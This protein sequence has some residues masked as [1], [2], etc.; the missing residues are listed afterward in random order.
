MQ[1]IA[2]AV[3]GGLGAGALGVL[4]LWLFRKVGRIGVG[5]TLGI[6]V[7][8]LLSPAISLS[9][10]FAGQYYRWALRDQQVQRVLDAGVILSQ[11]T[12]EEPTPATVYVVQRGDEQEEIQRRHFDP[13]YR[14]NLFVVYTVL[15]FMTSATFL[16]F[17]AGLMLWRRS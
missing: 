9:I 12:E 3:L 8:V 16:G 15:V 6:L 10:Q 5:L 1:S 7:V 14:P 2:L 11:R 13:I 4:L 17:G